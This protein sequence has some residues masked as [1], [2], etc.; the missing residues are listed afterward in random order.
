MIFDRFAQIVA[1]GVPELR[2][3]LAKSKLFHIDAPAKG[4][5]PTTLSDEQFTFLQNFFL[6]FQYTCVED[7]G[8]CTLLWDE[9]EG[10]TGVN[11]R[12]YFADCLVFGE[13]D[14]M[15]WLRDEE[16]PNTEF[17]KM[18]A[19][20]H[21]GA[22]AIVTGTIEDMP[23]ISP[24]CYEAEIR[25]GMLVIFDEHANIRYKGT[26][27]DGDRLLKEAT[28]YALEGGGRNAKIAIEW[29]IYLNDQSK[30][31]L[32]SCPIERKNGKPRKIKYSD[33]RPLYTVLTPKE[34]RKTMNLDEPK[35]D[36][37]GKRP[38]ERRAHMRYYTH[39]RYSEERR[40]KPQKIEAVWVGP[41][42][43]VVGNRRYR[44]R[45][46]L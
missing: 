2:S 35:V 33:E 46:D 7:I 40:A 18:V 30:F 25:L 21:P 44:V 43:A 42:E 24:S 22:G 27:A 31:V 16:T 17:Y 9:E 3:P 23:K 8:S 36:G 39:E 6:P 4:I 13:G 20:S 10:Q 38:H 32:E 45:L 34:I 12:R 11:C 29:I 26:G 19:E 37:T 15:S 5:L 28:S 1:A 41:R 14:D